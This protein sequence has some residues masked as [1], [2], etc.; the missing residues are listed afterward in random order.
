MPKCYLCDKISYGKSL[1][2]EDDLAII[3]RDNFPVTKL[4]TLIVPKVHESSIFELDSVVYN[5]LFNLVK[6]ESRN[7][8]KIDPKIL[9]YNV[10]INQGIVAGQT[11]MHVHIH[12]IP[13]RKD[14]VEDPRGG[15]RWVIP[16]RANYW[17]IY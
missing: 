1:A 11:V 12:L 13:R 6:I 9:G 15:V 4:H 3:L 5:H 2:Y 8:L 7:L 14:D 16:S 10:G 17:S